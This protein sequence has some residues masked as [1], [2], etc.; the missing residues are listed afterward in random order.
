MQGDVSAGGIMDRVGRSG[1]L[2]T[3]GEKI[4]MILNFTYLVLRNR[5]TDDTGN[6]TMKLCP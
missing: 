5:D 6:S 1:K 3:F 4:E 2:V